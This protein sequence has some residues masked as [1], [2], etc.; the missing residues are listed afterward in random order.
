M[1]TRGSRPKTL[2]VQ[3]AEL[4]AAH[5]GIIIMSEK[6]SGGSREGRVKLALLLEVLRPGDTLLVTKLD[7]MARDTVDMLELV[8]E[9]G[10]KGA[11]FK[12]IAESWADTTTPA[13][14][15]V[16]TIM[17]GVAQFERERIRERQAEGIKAAKANGAY[18]G[19][20]KRFSDSD[21]RKM[22]AEGM[23]A[24]EI[25]RTIGAKSTST[26]YRALNGA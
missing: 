25:M 16:L 23:G 11:G 5:P 26:V 14:T 7:R 8:R 13:G 1:A 3:E 17:A 4:K 19:G 15:L 10:A 21:I 2:D 24:T 12:S 9:I 18:K 22:H 20:A 6:V